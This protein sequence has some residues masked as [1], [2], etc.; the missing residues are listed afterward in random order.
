MNAGNFTYV[1]E[2]SFGYGVGVPQTQTTYTWTRDMIPGRT[3]SFVMWAGDAKRPRVGAEQHRDSSGTARRPHAAGRARDLRHRQD[4]LD[5]RPRVGPGCR[6]RRELLR[7]PASS[8]TA[9]SRSSGRPASGRRGCSSLHCRDDVR[10]H[11][12]R[13]R[14]VGERV[15]AE[16]PRR[17]RPQLRDHRRRPGRPRRATACSRSTSAARRGSSGP[18][19]TTT[20]TRSPRSSTRCA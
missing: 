4:L 9:P 10:V 17:R 19:R 15:R 1:I 2:A 5:G 7:L 14:P 13:R 16:C 6:R 8:S 3:Y 11:G 20:S 12:R 18:F